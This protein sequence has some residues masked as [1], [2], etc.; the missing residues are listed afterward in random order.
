MLYQEETFTFYYKEINR[1]CGNQVKTYYELSKII[2]SSLYSARVNFMDFMKIK[3]I[4][5]LT[6]TS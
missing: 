1:T 6:I 4:D 5:T 3:E 2:D